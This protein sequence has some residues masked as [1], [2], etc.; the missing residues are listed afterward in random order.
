ME[1]KG[2]EVRGLEGTGCV[3][4]KNLAIST[5]ECIRYILLHP[6][7]TWTLYCCDHVWAENLLLPRSCEKGK[8]PNSP[9]FLRK[10]MSEN[11]ST[12]HLSLVVYSC[13][14]HVKVSTIEWVLRDPEGLMCMSS[15]V[16]LMSFQCMLWFGDTSIKLKWI[17]W[18]VA[19]T[20]SK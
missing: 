17:E 7:L 11:G 14:S 18:N 13:V 20:R 2:S 9:E 1:V 3:V 19:Q 4:N 16:P 8:R 6:P 15:S 12:A 10:V 5:A